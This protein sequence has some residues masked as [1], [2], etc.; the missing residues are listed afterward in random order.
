[1]LLASLIAMSACQDLAK[2]ASG[3]R[4]QTTQSVR[5]LRGASYQQAGGARAC[6]AQIEQWFWSRC[7][8]PGCRDAKRPLHGLRGWT[9]GNELFSKGAKVPVET[10]GKHACACR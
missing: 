10:R 2:L 1:M 6:L 5:T 9:S 4:R 7:A 3:T 8:L